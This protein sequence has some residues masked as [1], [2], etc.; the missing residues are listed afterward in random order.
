M[1]YLYSLIIWANHRRIIIYQWFVAIY[2]S[3]HLIYPFNEEKWG[4]YSNGY[5]N[6]YNHIIP[7]L[8][9]VCIS[10]FL[11]R[12]S[13]LLVEPL[14]ANV[15]C[16]YVTSFYSSIHE[17]ACWFSLGLSLNFYLVL[18]C[19]KQ[20][21]LYALVCQL[22]FVTYFHFLVTPP[23]VSRRGHCADPRSTLFQ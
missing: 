3:L 13:W 21:S 6:Q 5:G 16:R 18:S 11:Q 7:R 15:K 8:T 9:S 4:N 19:R 17:C 23:C 20:S 12:W 14:S 1:F 10:L 22:L 2:L